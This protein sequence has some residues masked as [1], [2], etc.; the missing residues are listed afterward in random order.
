[1]TNRPSISLIITTYN[2]PEALSLIFQS[3]ETQIELPCEVIIADD[4]SVD[5]TRDVINFWAR[6]LPFTVR[7]IWQPDSSFRAARARNLAVLK[8]EGDYII[9][10]DGDCI[11]PPWF[12]SEHRRLMFP[13]KLV[14]GNR[15]LLSRGQ[16]LAI[17]E[18]S[19]GAIGN[20]FRGNKF[21][22][23]EGVIWRDLIRTT[24]RQVRSCNF[25]VE[26]SR[27]VAVGGFDERYQGWGLE[28]SDLVIRLIVSGTSIRNGRFAV[29]VEHLFHDHADR[30]MMGINT[31]RLKKI[32]SETKAECSSSVLSLCARDS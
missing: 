8:A 14:A 3:L 18:K 7:H 15:R 16:T 11:A 2:W 4:G 9:F 5:S 31:K 30:T 23:L 10:L 19:R 24:W 13:G 21:L 12:I 20:L 1:M 6:R 22:R 32:M 25:S 27:L 29:C 28:D 26:R 17:L